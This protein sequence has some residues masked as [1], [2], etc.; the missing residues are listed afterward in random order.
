MQDRS[1]ADIGDYVKLA[2]RAGARSPAEVSAR[3]D[4]FP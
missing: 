3:C 4:G 1:A 2:M